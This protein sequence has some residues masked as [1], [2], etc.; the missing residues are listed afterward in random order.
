[1]GAAR[2]VGL[3][4]VLVLV[5]EQECHGTWRGEGQQSHFSLGC[6]C[7]S[8]LLVRLVYVNVSC[9]YLVCSLALHT[10]LVGLCTELKLGPELGARKGKNLFYFSTIS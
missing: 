1:M 8:L 5:C 10:C 3:V 4:L 6:V 9:L 2:V 7:A